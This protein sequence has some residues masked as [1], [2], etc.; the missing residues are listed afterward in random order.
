[1]EFATIKLFALPE[2]DRS[3]TGARPERDR[4]GSRPESGPE[5]YYDA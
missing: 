1:M 4:S 3:G 2:R 5:A